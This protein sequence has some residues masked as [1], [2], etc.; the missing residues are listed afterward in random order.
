[1]LSLVMFLLLS[2]ALLLMLVLIVTIV[3]GTIGRIS[4]FSRTLLSLASRAALR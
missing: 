3:L 4:G 1:V 2:L